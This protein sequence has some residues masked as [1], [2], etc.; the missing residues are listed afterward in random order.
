MGDA[1]VRAE[2][3]T[4]RAT[5]EARQRAGPE[6]AGHDEAQPDLAQALPA[7]ISVG[8]ILRLQRAAGNAAVAELLGRSRSVQRADAPSAV[9]DPPAVDRKP[10]AGPQTEK[11]SATD[12]GKSP[13]GQLR[14]DA[15]PAAE[16]R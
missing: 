7:S 11:A 4:D 8:N 13:F 6:S 9:A 5:P 10:D 2:R 1:A 12:T 14:N 3:P 16:G 15:P